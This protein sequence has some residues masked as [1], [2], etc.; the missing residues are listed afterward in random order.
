VRI[1]NARVPSAI[2]VHDLQRLSA[3]A[4]QALPHAV[5]I[6]NGTATVG[7]L[8]PAHTLSR[9]YLCKVLADIEAAAARRSPEQEKVI[10][11]LRA[12]RGIE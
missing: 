5:P 9:K 11:Q 6:K 10:D 7:V 1:D 3:S 2:S 8:L 4:I 12:Q